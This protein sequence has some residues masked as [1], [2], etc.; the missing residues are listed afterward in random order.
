MFHI[1]KQ[2]A[3]LASRVN[4][5][6][7]QGDLYRLKELIRGEAHPNKTDYDGRSPLFGNT[8]L[9]EA[10]KN[11]HDRVASLLTKHGASLDI[12]DGCNCLCLAVAKGDS[13]FLKRL[14]SNG[15][16]PNSRDYDRRT[17]LHIA[18][19][20]GLYLMANNP[21]SSDQKKLT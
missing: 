18:A 11:G 6:V 20:E 21:F 1:G 4:I 5:S 3:E 12:D 8:P 15:V 16:D 9:F 14:L 10:I 19:V 13:D 2:E 17:P 7:F